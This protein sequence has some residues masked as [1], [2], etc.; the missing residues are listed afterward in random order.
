MRKEQQEKVTLQP[1]IDTVCETGEFGSCFFLPPFPPPSKT[2]LCVEM[3]FT[4]IFIWKQTKSLYKSR[5]GSHFYG[6]EIEIWVI[7]GQLAI[8]KKKLGRL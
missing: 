5:A 3:G 6:T 1:T 4:Q 2:P 7:L 8:L